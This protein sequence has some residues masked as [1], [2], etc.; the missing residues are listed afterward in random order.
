MKHSR[1]L[2]VCSAVLGG[3]L[4]FYGCSS[5][6]ANS[7]AT[8]PEPNASGSAN[9]AKLSPAEGDFVQRAAM[10][11][12]AE[13]ELGNVAQQNASSD[14]VKQ[15]G[16]RM[17]QDHSKASKELERLVSKKG[18]A[19]SKTVDEEQRTDAVKFSKIS[20]PNFD[21]AYMR[22]MVDDHKKTLE[23][24]QHQADSA[25][26]PDVRSFAVNSLPNLQDHLRQAQEVMS[27]LRKK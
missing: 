26:D 6:S 12:R 5:N 13:V 11:S 10:D 8:A 25:Q 22:E 19:L 1:K 18:I 2:V 14:A 3:S 27:S 20:G 9:R 7:T 4:V 21:L 17:V 15:F 24:F 16:Q 23:E